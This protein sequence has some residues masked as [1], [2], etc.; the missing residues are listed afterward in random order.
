M[1][2]FS[3]I[4]MI[5]LSVSSFASS[6]TKTF[7]F[8]GSQSSVMMTLHAE[9][10]HTEYRYE[11]RSTM[12]QRTVM[13]YQTICTGGPVPQ[14]TTRPVARI[15]YYPCTITVSVPYEVKDYD[16]EANVNL[17]VTALAGAI[18]G[19]TFKVTLNGD[20]LSLS[21]SSSASK[22]FVMLNKREISSTMN[23][24]IKFIDASYRASFIEAAPITKALE[25][26]NISLKD[27]V[28]SFSLGPVAVREAIGFSLEVKKAPIL[29]SD[30]VI[31]D[32]ELNASEI[33][34][35]TQGAGSAADINIQKLGVEVTSGRYT[36]TAKAFFKYAG[37]VL[38]A[39]Q[40]EALSASRTLIYKVR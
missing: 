7:F 8:D 27:N 34:L 16:V 6:Q 10:T 40:F 35:S 15:I 4:A 26:T 11:Q 20:L 1:K 22:Y 28:L 14:C 5:L 17:D 21:A 3:A 9:K 25:L 24:S 32:R 12:C 39:S 19:E 31:F 30:T 23:G 33:Q 13:D 18:H 38:N 36:L 37:T 2:T 29:G